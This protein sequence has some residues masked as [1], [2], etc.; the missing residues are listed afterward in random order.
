MILHDVAMSGNVITETKKRLIEEGFLEDYVCSAATLSNKTNKTNLTEP[1]YSGAIVKT[2]EELHLPWGFHSR[3]KRIATQ[4]EQ[5]KERM[6]SDKGPDR[7]AIEKNGVN[8]DSYL[9]DEPDR[10][11]YGVNLACAYP[12]PR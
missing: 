11:V 6:Y 9:A 7:T 5:A 4:A 3:R 10:P 2:E 8:T 12:F 1:D